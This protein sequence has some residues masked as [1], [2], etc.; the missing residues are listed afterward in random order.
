MKK[1]VTSLALLLGLILFGCAQ[2]R[3]ADATATDRPVAKTGGQD[4]AVPV[5]EIPGTV[6]K[7]A[8]DAVPGF[9][10][11]GAEKEIEHGTTVYSLEG[12][13]DGKA[14]EVEVTADGKVTEIEK[15]DAEDEDNDA[16]DED[17]E[18][19]DD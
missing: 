15:G 17:G 12:T 19:D 2:T 5:G 6:L 7:A 3:S 8:Q 10:P 18:N 4:E 1:L 14:C 11:T 16:D 9:T 13:A